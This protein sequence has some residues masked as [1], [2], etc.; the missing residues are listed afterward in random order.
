MYPVPW[1]AASYIPDRSSTTL[2]AFLFR[3]CRIPFSSP[4]SVL[5]SVT[6]ARK[7]ITSWKRRMAVVAS[8]PVMAS[9]A[10]SRFSRRCSSSGARCSSLTASSAILFQV[11]A[12]STIWLVSTLSS[13]IWSDATES[14][15]SSRCVIVFSAR[16]LPVITPSAIFTAVT[17]LSDIW[18][19]VIS[20]SVFS[21]K[22]CITRATIWLVTLSGSVAVFICVI[23]PAIKFLVSDIFFIFN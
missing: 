5:S 2:F 13:S 10:S 21:R 3:S 18:P 22:Y 14:V 16:W 1:L 4:V 19:V 9:M 23:S 7:A 17:A 8:S 15:P 11:T 6:P 12:L 20:S